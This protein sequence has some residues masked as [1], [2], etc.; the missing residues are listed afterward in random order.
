MRCGHWLDSRNSPSEWLPVGLA[1]KISGRSIYVTTAFPIFGFGLSGVAFYPGYLSS[2]SIDQYAQSL[3]RHFS[4]WHPPVMAFVWSLFDKIWAGPELMLFAQLILF[5]LAAFLLLTATAR[6]CAVWAQM[7]LC[8]MLLC[9]A[10][11]NFVGVIWTDVQLA[12]AWSFV[13]AVVFYQQSAGERIAGPIRAALLCIVAYG[14]LVRHN[15]GL[16]AGPL[17][18]YLLYG[19]GVFR[20]L[21]GTLSAYVIVGITFIIFGKGVDAALNA[22]HTPIL[23]ALILFDLTGT[24]FYQNEPLFPFKVSADEWTLIK[25]CYGDGSAV[26]PLIWGSC[27]FMWS[28]MLTATQTDLSALY[29]WVFT[30]GSH[31]ISY[32]VH[33][34]TYMRSFLSFFTPHASQFIWLDGIAKNQYGLVAPDNIISQTLKH[35]V[36]AFGWTPLFR[37]YFWLLAAGT[38]LVASF[39]RRLSASTADFSRAA[40]LISILYFLSYTVVGIASD[41]RYGYVSIVLTIFGGGA[42]LA[43]LNRARC[44]Y[45]KYSSA[46]NP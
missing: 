25:E 22:A 2:D 20:T 33:R 5:W 17:V 29:L 9:P 24:S 42:V 38:V 36:Y 14:G 4:D 27:K 21:L 1:A 46:G 26:D 43:D 23:R 39:N 8:A 35:Y 16:A 3:T 19:A 31:P 12:T 18:L 37:L 30:V 10:V 11:L 28:R 40:S 13:A 6:D 7:L 44:N 34:L 45:F 41:F 32:L 15:A